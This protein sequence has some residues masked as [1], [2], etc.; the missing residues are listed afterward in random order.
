LPT[1]DELMG[2]AERSAPTRALLPPAR[3][4]KSEPLFKTP[5]ERKRKKTKEQPD[6]E[7]VPVEVP[8]HRSDLTE[9][10]PEIVAA[11]ALAAPAP[12][13]EAPSIEIH[14]EISDAPTPKPVIVLPEFPKL[15]KDKKPEAAAD[16]ED[17]P[18]YIK[19]GE[20]EYQLPSPMLLDFV[21]PAH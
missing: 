10:S 5:P 8:D 2:R 11:A 16:R 15:K 9:K 3:T 4:Q 7:A 1:R 19:V 17:K 13:A 18:N 12:L 6:A 14:D 21:E 20:G